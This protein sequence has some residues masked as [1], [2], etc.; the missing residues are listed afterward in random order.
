MTAPPGRPAWWARLAVGLAARPLPAG[1][2]DRYRR[3]F[4][5]ELYGMTPAEQFRHAS[6]VVARAWALRRAVGGPAATA[7][8]WPCLAIHR[9]KRLRNPEG[10]WYREC[11]DCG[12]QALDV[13]AV[14][15]RRVGW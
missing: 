2:R 9:W 5:A 6:G 4:L 12:K 10:G 13:V 1:K 14:A 7:T 15:D 3:E 8:R 11:P